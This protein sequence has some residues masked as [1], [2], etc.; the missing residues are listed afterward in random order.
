MWRTNTKINVIFFWENINTPFMLL[1]IKMQP[2]DNLLKISNL[3]DYQ[4]S[5]H[6][7]LYEVVLVILFRPS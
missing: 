5:A 4:H 2:K 3:T 1:V 7:N 6:V